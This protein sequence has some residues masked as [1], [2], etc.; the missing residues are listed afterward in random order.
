VGFVSW[1]FPQ[2]QRLLLDSGQATSIALL[3]GTGVSQAELQQQV[4]G[5]LPP[6]TRSVTGEEQASQIS[7]Q[8][9]SGLG[10]LNTFLL[11][12]AVV[13]VFVAAS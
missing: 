5:L 4:A 11:V 12:F 3:A 6:G 9:D 8:L 2:A 1:D 13:S 10:F 7:E